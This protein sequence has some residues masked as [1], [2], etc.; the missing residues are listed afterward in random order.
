MQ[1]LV[2]ILKWHC[3]LFF[4]EDTDHRPPSILL[5]TLAGRAYRGDVDR[6]PAGRSARAGAR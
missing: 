1:R 5:T 2:Q 6:P 4:A 3:M